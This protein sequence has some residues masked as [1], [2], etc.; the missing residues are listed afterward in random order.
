MN[1]STPKTARRP[2]M[3]M[4]SY[5]LN[6]LHLRN[7]WVIAWWSLTFPGFGH[8]ACGSMAKGIFVF[9]GE[10][11]INQMSKINLAILYSFTGEFQ[12]AKTVLN[13]QW[14]L[15]YCA[16]LVF[17]IW[18]SYRIAIEINKFSVLADRENAPITTTIIGGSAFNFLDKRNPRA[19]IAWSMLAPG[20]GQ[21]YNSETVKAIFL[22]LISSVVIVASHSLQAIGYTAWGNFQ[23]AKAII[24]WQ[25][26][27]NIPS[28]YC[29]AAWEAYVDSVELNKLFDIE[30]AQFF[31]N[32]FQ[33]PDFKKPLPNAGG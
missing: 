7:P 2:K 12:K 11:V 27:L 22:L 16:I 14:L 32:N 9:I 33:S 1:P 31:R 20:L 25:L 4:V 30:Q 17:A 13:M 5:S 23:Q 28:F 8:M 24:N 15:L 3:K 10:L 21:L 29:F 6:H 19:S 26:L 18:D